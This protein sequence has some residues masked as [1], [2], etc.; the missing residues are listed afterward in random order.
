MAPQDYS[1]EELRQLAAQVVEA[2]LDNKSWSDTLAERVA[3][4]VECPQ[5]TLC[6]DKDHVCTTRTVSFSC[7]APF[8]CSNGHV[9]KVQA[10]F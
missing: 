3:R 4:A 1:H 7:S 6:C 2:I 10:R 5:R 9:E 8:Q